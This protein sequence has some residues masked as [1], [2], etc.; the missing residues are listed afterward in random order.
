MGWWLWHKGLPPGW[1]VVT[2]W[3]SDPFKTSLSPQP[4]E[5]ATADSLG[6]CIFLLSGGE[7]QQSFQDDLINTV[8]QSIEKVDLQV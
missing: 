3:L 7:M 1:E 8:N 6:A 4:P 5:M 2:Q